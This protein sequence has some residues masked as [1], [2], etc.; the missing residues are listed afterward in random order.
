LDIL[1]EAVEKWEK[2]DATGELM[3]IMF[4]GMLGDRDPKTAEKLKEEREKM[5]KKREDDSRKRKERGCLLR[6]KMITIKDSM[7]AKDFLGSL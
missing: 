7:E 6:A 5:M 4:E 1:F 3:G 2:V